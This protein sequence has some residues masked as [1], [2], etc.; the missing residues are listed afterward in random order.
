M[1]ND[2]TGII[3]SGGKSTRMGTNKSLLKLGDKTVIERIVDL[4]N[5]LFGR[6]ILSTNNF[7][8]YGFLDLEMFEDI[9]NGFGPIGGIHSG[10]LHSQTEKNFIISCDIPLISAGIIKFLVNYPTNKPITIAKADGFIQQLCGIYS[11]NVLP[12]IEKI[13]KENITMD[14]RNRESSLF[15]TNR[16]NSLEL[17]QKKRGCKVLQLVAAVESEIIDIEKEYSSYVPG[18]FLNM[19]NPE[20]YE[21]LK[22]YFSNNPYA[23]N[24]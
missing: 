3:L 12:E 14:E 22:N 24:M 13:I 15:T 6:V 2:V 21:Q 7:D 11:K 19:N 18:T 16:H 17:E 20:E 5:P 10:L 23:K 1:Y 4:M 9:Y 8:E